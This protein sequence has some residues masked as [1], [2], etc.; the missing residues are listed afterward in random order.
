[1]NTDITHAEGQQ[2]V[3]Q[4]YFNLVETIAAKIKR[5]LP[6]HV[7][8]QDL[9]QTGMIGLLEAS[10]RYDASRAVEFSTYASSRITGAILDELRKW[11]T[12]SR[13]DR[14]NARQ[15]EQAKMQLTAKTGENPSNEQIAEAV[16]LGLKEYEL[17]LNRLE[18]GR[19]PF[20]NAEDSESDPADEIS[21]IPSTSESP[22][23]A[24]SKREDSKMLRSHIDRLQP[25]YREIL[26]LYYFK[27]MGLKEI[28][29]RMGVGE[30][31]IS[32]LHKQAV[33]E[34]RRNLDSERRPSAPH[35]STLVQ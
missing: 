11:D 15:I 24:C 30:A 27:G 22:F 35:N 18:S 21:R 25:R 13:K 14:K 26:M 28:G 1:M 9:V 5:R 19:Q 29:R 12:C 10:S 33:L 7:D 2:V 6:S 32:Q 4:N 20:F 16:G 3:L 34:L 23:E 31:R 17:T 8:V